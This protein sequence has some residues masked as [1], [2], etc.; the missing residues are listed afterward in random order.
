MGNSNGLSTSFK[1]VLNYGDSLQTQQLEANLLSYL[2]WGL[3]CI[4][5]F[6]NVFVNTSGVYDGTVPESRLTLV[7]DPNVVDGTE[8]QGFRQNWVW[9]QNID[10]SYQPIPISGIYVDGNFVP[11]NDTG[12]YAH[13]VDY[14]AGRVVFNTP[15]TGSPSIDCEYSFRHVRVDLGDSPWFQQIQF[16]SYRIDD[17]DFILTG[18]GAW[19]ILAENRIQLPAIVLEPVFNVSK[20]PWEIGSYA[21]IHSQDIIFNILTETDYDRKQLHDILI[22][23]SEITIRAFDKDVLLGA[24]GYPLNPY[25][26]LQSGALNYKQIVTSGVY[27][28]NSKIRFK[29][30]TSDEVVSDP[31]L[32]KSKVRGSFEMYLL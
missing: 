11:K 22:N 19:N 32:Y 2:D 23:Q 18:S 9:E 4:G 30:M 5:A 8:Y 16:N 29:K 20:I 1:G 12:V 31:P 25:G 28:W 6:Q 14:P 21:N 26:Y 27:D 13:N 10:Y 7:S 24:S 17:P 15:I 3:L